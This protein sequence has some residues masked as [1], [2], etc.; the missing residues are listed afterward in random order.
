MT[1]PGD[2][3]SEALSQTASQ[4]APTWPRV[5][6]V[7]AVFALAFFVAKNCQDAQ[8]EV[9]QAEAVEIATGQVD[10]RPEDTQI[11]LLRQGINRQPFWVVSLSTLSAN[12]Q[13]YDDLAVVRIDATSG[14]IVESSDQRVNEQAPSGAG[15]E[16]PGARE[17]PGGGAPQA[18]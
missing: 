15:G 6:V 12:G 10:F 3:G 5:A 7:A 16:Q 9:T 17:Q 8:V 4:R 2:A 13:A 11:R 14:K 18:P 1:S